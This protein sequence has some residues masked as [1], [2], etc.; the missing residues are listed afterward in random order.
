M[1]KDGLFSVG[2][3]RCDVYLAGLDAA[4]AAGRPLAASATSRK[5][6]F[7]ASGT[8]HGIAATHQDQV[9]A[10]LLAFISNHDH[11]S[12]AIPWMSQ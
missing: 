5:Q 2:G 1:S 9:N 7:P 3:A 8:P 4:V 10:D 12:S 11:A 6:N